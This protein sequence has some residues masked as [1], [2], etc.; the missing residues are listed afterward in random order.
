MERVIGIVIFSLI[1]VFDAK[2]VLD[3]KL[4]GLHCM[5]ELII[6]KSAYISKIWRQT[7]GTKQDIY[8]TIIALF[9]QRYGFF[10]LEA[11]LDKA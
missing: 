4:L 3:E 11:S 1:G 8:I 6:P 9:R 2:E 5:L 7:V 10:I